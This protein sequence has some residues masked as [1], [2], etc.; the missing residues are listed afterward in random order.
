MTAAALTGRD[1]DL[2]VVRTF[3]DDASL[4]GA[5][6]LLT[7][8]PGVGKT[9][10]LDAAHDAAMAAGI[11]VLRAAGVEF[12]ADVSFSGLNQVLLPLGEE[13]AELS[14][15]YQDALKVALGLIAGPPSDRLLV[16]NAALALL[17]QAAAA[18]PL[19]VILD[20]LPWLD[21]AS[22]LVLGFVAR[23]LGGSR[24]GFLAAART[25]AETFF[26]AGGLPDHE[27]RPL[28]GTAAAGLI[29]ARFPDLA[30][31]V[32]RRVLAEA[33]GN[34]LALLEL[35]L[36]LNGAQRRALVALPPI[37][38]LGGRLQALFSSRAS[39]LPASTR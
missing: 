12:E 28:D 36:A 17:R 3:L 13:L 14:A 39:D 9:A 37:L 8:E 22:A 1:G 16:S 35:P 4:S 11:R 24:V 6:L 18:R 15:T 26:D 34:P 7:G 2:D 30:P 31:A 33:Q 21:R 27:V 38:P 25:G 10:L 23:R 5:A 29:S 32:R 20:D 19:L